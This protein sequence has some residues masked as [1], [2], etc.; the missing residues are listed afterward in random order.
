MVKREI[1]FPQKGNGIACVK[2]ASC[3]TVTCKPVTEFN[4]LIRHRSSVLDGKV[5]GADRI[6]NQ[7]NEIMNGVAPDA[8]G[9]NEKQ[10]S[11]KV[12][13]SD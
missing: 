10:S 3:L 2:T 12:S 13:I 6:N 1:K 5:L 11:S 7:F 4:L 8:G 9:K